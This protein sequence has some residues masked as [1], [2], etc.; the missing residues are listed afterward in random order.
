MKTVFT[1]DMCAHVFAQRTQDEGR[2]NNGNMFFCGDTI[3]SYGHHF[4]MAHFFNDN[5]VLMNADSYSVST[6]GHQSA[7]R[8]AIDNRYERIWLDTAMMKRCI[9]AHQWAN[10]PD[11]PTIHVSDKKQIEKMVMDKMQAALNS[12]AKRRAEHLRNADINEALT[13]LKNGIRVLELFG[14]KSAR[15]NN[16]LSTVQADT[17]AVLEQY[18]EAQKRE[19][20]K[21]KKEAVK[22]VKEWIAGDIDSIP[23]KYRN[24]TIHLRVNGDEIQTSHGARFPLEHGVK[25]FPMIKRCKD[26]AISWKTNG[27]TIRLGHFRID[28][29]RTNGTVKAGCHTVPYES[30]E[31]V[32][33]QL[34][35]I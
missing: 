23:Y 11:K 29:I 6:S 34:N 31:R 28:E 9:D 5:V 30:I 19:A 2:T 18:S 12:A 22:H 13:E 25:A 16:A 4:P 1:N 15:L 32:A 3:Y 14:R 8:M 24:G 17:N 35:L 10:N 20:A 33:R 26:K 7:V 21:L 27:E